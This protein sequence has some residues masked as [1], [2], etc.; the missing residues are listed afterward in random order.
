M[1]IEKMDDAACIA[2][3]QGERIGRLGCCRD[4]RPYV[5]P[6]HYVCSGAL[7]FSFTMPGQKL[8]FMRDNPNVCLQVES[9]ERSDKWKCVLVQGIFREFTFEAD[10]QEAWKVLQ[11]HN[12]WCEVGGQLV[13]H[14]EH[15]SDRKPIFFSITMDVTTGREALERRPM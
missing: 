3:I 6:V 7:I 4:G 12:D 1:N 15:D 14:G 8:D 9:I 13:Q 10:Q 2:L 5:V 11:Q